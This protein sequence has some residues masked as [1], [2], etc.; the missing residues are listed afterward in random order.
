MFRST[1][2]QLE[3][4]ES[5]KYELEASEKLLL[6]YISVKPEILRMS[7][8]QYIAWLLE[9]LGANLTDKQMEVLRTMPNIE[10]LLRARRKIKN[11]NFK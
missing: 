9:A 11:E 5:I 1:P 8:N 4:F 6:P 10:T 7:T 2:K 3:A